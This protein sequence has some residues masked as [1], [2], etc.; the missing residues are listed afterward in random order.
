MKEIVLVLTLLV[1]AAAFVEVSA[2]PDMLTSVSQVTDAKPNDL[3]Y[4]DLQNLIE[5]YGVSGMTVG[6]KL[7][8][9]SPVTAT[10]FQDISATGRTQVS[11]FASG[12][13]NR[14]LATRFGEKCGLSSTTAQAP[15]TEAQA[16]A[17]L[18]CMFGA[19]AV[20]GSP[21]SGPLSRGMFMT[22][23][24]NSLSAAIDA[25]SEMSPSDQSV[26][27][28]FENQVQT[29]ANAK[30]YPA[31]LDLYAKLDAGTYDFGDAG[32]QRK[33][34]K[35]LGVLTAKASILVALKRYNEADALYYASVDSSLADAKLS[36]DQ[37]IAF[38]AK[39][40]SSETERVM[41]RASQSLAKAALIL[42]SSTKS[43][44][45][46]AYVLERAEPTKRTFDP[47]RTAR[48]ADLQNLLAKNSF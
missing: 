4:L 28:D 35:N 27:K 15:V 18:R 37:L 2:Q 21:G 7:L 10:Y 39:T 22:Y 19:N 1:S 20:T 41:A 48:L 5:R 45:D 14:M 11:Q 29:L 26:Q 31:A 47:A 6:G 16:V 12:I 24:N 44:R 36:I 38:K 30:Q 9:S 34:A 8:P 13:P 46:T 33:A 42:A 17:T 3:F 25:I 40:S 43:S 32:M 23:L